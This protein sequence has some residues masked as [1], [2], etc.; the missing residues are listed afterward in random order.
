MLQDRD[1]M[2]LALKEAQKAAALE[3]IP[4]GAVLVVDGKV[5]AQGHN[6]RETKRDATAHAE[7]LVI[8]EACAKLGKWRLTDATLYVTLEPCPMCAGA[9]YNARIGRL[10]YG[11]VDSRAGGCESVFNITSNAHLNHQCAVTA[12]VLSEE[13]SCILKKFLLARR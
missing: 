3:E 9:I 11:A 2:A 7:M 8:Q 6:E 1:F 10:V 13:C 4:V 5:I 12:G